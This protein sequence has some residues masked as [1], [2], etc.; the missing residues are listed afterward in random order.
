MVRDNEITLYTYTLYNRRGEL[1][2]VRVFSSSTDLKP[3]DDRV[4]IDKWG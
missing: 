4:W 2:Y 1:Y 3:S